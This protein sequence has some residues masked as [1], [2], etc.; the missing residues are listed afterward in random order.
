MGKFFNT[1]ILLVLVSCTVPQEP[2]KSHASMIPVQ[3]N[4]GDMDSGLAISTGNAQFPL[5]EIMPLLDNDSGAFEKGY[6]FA[7]LS[8]SCDECAKQIHQLNELVGFPIMPKVFAFIL[9]DE[10]GLKI[11]HERYSP[12]FSTKLLEPK[13]FFQFIG[14]TPPRFMYVSKGQVVKYWDYEVPSL[15]EIV[16]QEKSTI[17]PSKATS[18]E[19]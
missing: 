8:A 12:R 5:H 3:A 1:T 6:L 10:E 2:S 9:G 17:L 14:T 13:R 11:L 18:K 4:T 19:W 7:F 15:A 16:S